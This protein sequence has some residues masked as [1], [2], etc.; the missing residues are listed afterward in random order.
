MK[1]LLVLFVFPVLFFAQVAF[2]DVSAYS[3]TVAGND[4]NTNS[5]GPYAYT[6]YPAPSQGLPV[7]SNVTSLTSV[8]APIYLKR[9]GG[10]GGNVKVTVFCK[11]EQGGMDPPNCD[12]WDPYGFSS[13]DVAVS[14]E[15]LVTTT[16]VLPATP[17]VTAGN[18]I[19]VNFSN[20]SNY[21][22]VHL[23]G[24]N[25]GYGDAIGTFLTVRGAG[26]ETPAPSTGGGFDV[27]GSSASATALVAS[28]ATAAQ[29]TFTNSWPLLAAIVG[30][31]IAFFIVAAI[32]MMF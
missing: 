15:T 19:I 30:I 21:Y 18:F 24:T 10:N 2:A 28:A 8:V 16:F 9:D 6:P 1:N 13:E 27:F 7:T 22:Y 17:P 31:P 25:D 3:Y 14:G 12:G 26:D 32:L 4:V 5:Q 23:E 29:T 20:T 11:T